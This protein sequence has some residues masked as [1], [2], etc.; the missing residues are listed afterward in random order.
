M[1]PRTCAKQAF[2]L[3][4]IV[5]S[6]SRRPIA[7]DRLR[8]PVFAVN[9]RRCLSSKSTGGGNSPADDGKNSTEVN[10]VDDAQ[11]IDPKESSKSARIK[12]APKVVLGEEM[13]DAIVGVAKELHG[14]SKEKQKQT[15]VDLLSV[16]VSHEKES[17][18]AATDGAMSEL[19]ADEGIASLVS[20]MII[21]KKDTSRPSTRGRRLRPSTQPTYAGFQSPSGEEV[22]QLD[23]ISTM[24]SEMFATSAEPRAPTDR[25]RSKQ[26]PTPTTTAINP[27]DSFADDI[28]QWAPLGKFDKARF[29]QQT[30]AP[31]LPLWSRLESDA[32]KTLNKGI[33]PRNAFE[34]T[35][36]W[37]EKG[38]LWPYPIN[39]EYML[40]QEQEVGFH[41]HVF[42]E[43]HLQR[44]NFPKMGP[45]RHFMELV[46]NGLSKNPYMTVTKKVEH[47][48]W[49]AT[50]FDEQRVATV[51][52][53]HERGQQDAQQQLQ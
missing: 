37:T 5:P 48:E 41:D 35:I 44:L 49:F 27:S 19:A 18:K 14:D 16:L 29:A 47:L 53:L 26:R 22:D 33:G 11:P 50:Y 34:E 23:E 13:M 4:R 46:C 6:A 52:R 31:T 1:L 15:T 38:K 42:L 36:D 20:G 51:T 39:N 7:I 24:A 9:G 40:G 28:F 8:C 12:P 2:R 17:Y 43:R 32:V 25:R 45:I 10:A 21:A 3:A 30:V